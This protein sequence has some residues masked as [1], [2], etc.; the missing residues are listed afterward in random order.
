MDNCNLENS[1]HIKSFI[2]RDNKYMIV[3]HRKAGYNVYDM[4]QD[5]WVVQDKNMILESD[6]VRC[7]FIN[8]EIIVVSHFDKLSFYNIMQSQLQ[9]KQLEEKEKEKEKQNINSDIMINKETLGNFGNPYLFHEISTGGQN[10]RSYY[11]RN[12]AF[13]GMCMIDYKKHTYEYNKQFRVKDKDKSKKKEKEK[14]LKDLNIVVTR[15][16][17]SFLIF[18]G[19]ETSFFGALKRIDATFEQT[20]QNSDINEQLDLICDVKINQLPEIKLLNFGLGD[21]GNSDK[22]LYSFGCLQQCIYNMKNERI[23]LFIG[24]KYNT[25]SIILWNYDRNTM[26]KRPNFLPFGCYEDPSCVLLGDLCLVMQDNNY[27]LFDLKYFFKQ[28]KQGEY[29]GYGLEKELFGLDI[30]NKLKTISNVYFIDC[31]KI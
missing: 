13:N 29:D 1:K 24:G 10:R 28:S 14:E 4:E 3:I 23:I 20:S 6:F 22:K 8:D 25:K 19:S 2:T 9:Q 11:Y 5:K 30:I 16:V 21:N 31:L 15:Y 26:I 17:I 12:G 27:C 18:G 7:L